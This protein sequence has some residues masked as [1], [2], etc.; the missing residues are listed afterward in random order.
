MV[1][2]EE[3]LDLAIYHM[4][5]ISWWQHP[6]VLISLTLL[7]VALLAGSFFGYRWLKTK[8]KKKPVPQ[9]LLLLLV[10]TLEGVKQGAFQ[11]ADVLTTIMVVLKAYTAW[12]TYNDLVLAMTDLQWLTYIKGFDLFKPFVADCAIII[13]KA[14]DI[15]FNQQQP[16]LSEIADLVRKVIV[17]I[18][19]TL[20]PDYKKG[21]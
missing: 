20:P 21:P 7:C 1:Q 3:Q 17:I 4:P 9:Q 11:P 8:K 18:A 16:A 2:L 10:Q 13:N 15:K 5:Y 6:Y 12:L 19:K 14:R